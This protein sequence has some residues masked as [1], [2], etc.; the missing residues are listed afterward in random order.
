MC[1]ITKHDDDDNNGGNML[2]SD[3]DVVDD[4]IC[5]HDLQRLSLY[6]INP[7][8]PLRVGKQT[9]NNRK[10]RVLFWLVIYTAWE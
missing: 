6:K 3:D 5:A 10:K 7:T 2:S 1:A 4:N 8:Q 9:H